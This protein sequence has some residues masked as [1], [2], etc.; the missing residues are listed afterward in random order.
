MKKSFTTLLLAAF[1]LSTIYGQ[2]NSGN[3]GNANGHAKPKIFNKGIIVN[4]STTLN[5]NVFINRDDA[6]AW[7]IFSNPGVINYSMGI[8][9]DNGGAFTIN[10]GTTLGQNTPLIFSRNGL[11]GIGIRPNYALDLSGDFNLTGDIR[12][13]GTVLPAMSITDQNIAVWNTS[14]SWGNHAEAGYLTSFTE[15]DPVFNQH[16]ASNITQTDIDNWGTAYEWGNHASFGYI[17]DNFLSA[18]NYLKLDSSLDLYLPGSILDNE[19]KSGS[20]GQILSSTGSGISWVDSKNAGQWVVEDQSAQTGGAYRLAVLPKDPAINTIDL[21]NNSDNVLTQIMVTNKNDESNYA[22]AVLV[23]KGSGP[24][25]TNN[26]YMG[27]YSENFYI[28]SW[29]GNGVIATDQDMVLSAL[30]RVDEPNPNPNPKIVFQ[31]GGDYVNDPIT[32]MILDEHGNLGIGT[33]DPI[34]KLDVTG[35]ILVRNTADNTGELKLSSLNT[36]ITVGFK[37]P[38]R[39]TKNII[40]TLPSGPGNAGQVL[41]TDGSGNLNWTDDAD[42]SVNSAWTVYESIQSITPAYTDYRVGIGTSNPSAIFEVNKNSNDL[43]SAYIRNGAGRAKGLLIK[44]GWEGSSSSLLQLEDNN[45]NVRMKVQANGKVGIGTGTPEHLLTVNG[46]I[47]AQDIAVSGTLNAQEVIIAMDEWKDC[48]FEPA[49][50][51]M[52]LTDLENYINTHKHLPDIP[53]EAEIIARGME[54]GEIVK[55]QMQ[56]IEELTLYII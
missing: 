37:A 4:G 46:T 21:T 11:F 35:D 28:D 36:D 15:T 39:V 10:K 43:W 48:V 30:G 19:Q 16:I 5:D 18:N 14:F 45:D 56:K 25:F 54:T 29:A 22:G 47:G 44:A 20:S 41:S 9:F 53:S 17:S 23:A 31:T 34:A 8:D 49:Y 51:L 33:E 7:M 40:W 27:K 42:G 2:G 6:D 24:E 1:A 13:N 55:Q 26:M 38:K 50:Q 52:P 32:R 12:K 3:T